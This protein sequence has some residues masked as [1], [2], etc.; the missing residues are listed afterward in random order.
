MYV[1]IQGIVV[2]IGVGTFIRVMVVAAARVI[3]SQ[4]PPV[5]VKYKQAA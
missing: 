2:F 4:S 5:T 1:H 3:V